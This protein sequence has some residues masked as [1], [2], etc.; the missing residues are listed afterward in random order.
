MKI[1]AVSDRKHRTLYDFFDPERFSDID[2][3]I[4]CGDLPADYLSFI[5]TMIPVPLL[6]VPGN[7]DG[8]FRKEPPSGCDSI[9]GRLFAY[10]GL[11]VGGLGGSV[12]Y[13]GEGFQYRE[14][15]MKR[16][17]DRLLRSAAR[18]GGMDILVAHAPPYGIHDLSDPCHHGF[19]A[20]RR[21]IDDK[22]FRVFVHG[23][24]HEIHTRADRETA[25]DG[26]RIINAFE[27]Y[28]FEF[29]EKPNGG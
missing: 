22:K 23:H 27:Y 1:L 13:N 21:A 11:V 10:R 18:M 3:V 9:D 6:F 5:V 17:F 8:K 20:F 19:R 7:H 2:L 4:S 24:T 28:V 15:E 29:A 12:W 25:V 26:I 16:R 14:K